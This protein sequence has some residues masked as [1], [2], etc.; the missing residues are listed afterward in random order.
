MILYAV[1]VYMISTAD[2]WFYVQ[3]IASSITFTTTHNPKSDL[4]FDLFVCFPLDT[5]N[6]KFNFN[7]T[8]TRGMS[9]NRFSAFAF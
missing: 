5:F 2:C 3:W 9:N 7:K 1:V 8:K 4:P 6:A